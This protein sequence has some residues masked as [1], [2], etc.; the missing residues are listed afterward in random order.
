MESRS[1]IDSIAKKTEHFSGS[2]L[3]ELC[4]K[5]LMISVKQAISKNGVV[6]SAIRP[7]SIRDIEAVLESV[8]NAY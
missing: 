4:R 7:L 6:Q 1:L 2:D 8:R 5:A 3:K